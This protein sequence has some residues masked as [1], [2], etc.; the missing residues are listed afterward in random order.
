MDRRDFLL[1]TGLALGGAALTSTAGCATAAPVPAPSAVSTDPWETMRGEFELSRDEI[2]MSMFLLAPHPRAVRE[3]IAMYRRALDEN[4]FKAYK[5]YAPKAE[6]EVCRAAAA[7][8]EVKPEELALTDSTTMGLALVYGGLR[9]REGQEVITSTH[10]HYA[11][12]QSLRLR[13]E[14]TGAVVRRIPLY[15]Q[16]D[17][18][19]EEE[20]VQRV[21]KAVTP[22]TRV[23]ALTWV[24][25]SSGVKLPIRALS[26]ALARVNVDRAEEDRVL[27]V[28]DGVHGIGVEDASL[29]QLGCDFFIAGCH[30]WLFGPRGTGFI[31]GKPHAWKSLEATIPTFHSPYVRI[32][33]KDTP[34]Q[35][36]PPGPLMTP[37]GFHSFE[38]RWALGKAF[39]F[40]QQ[41][42]RRN[43]AE[44]IHA[45]N[46][47]AKEGLAKM[48]HVQLRTPMAGELSAGIL[49]FEVKGW[50]A[51]D[52]VHRL[53]ER[54]IIATVTPYVTKYVRISPSLF[55]SPEEVD[56]VLKEIHALA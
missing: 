6:A 35:E 7:Y 21:L 2:H 25:S 8:L 3:A 51:S 43:V 34:F 44:R 4:P 37:G 26:D 24:L 40:H 28:V 17:T 47:Q 30:K 9:L 52:A 20:I 11:T 48:P 15:D 49:C 12:D 29:P 55:N 33:A 22:R 19:T 46:R 42:G 38:H 5:Q 18:A 13:E 27:F 53:E 54:R 16:P 45:L 10:E 39:E 56:T 14:R 23:V 36:L 1:R 50:K 32:W 31:W 41:L